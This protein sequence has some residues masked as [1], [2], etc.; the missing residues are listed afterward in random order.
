MTTYTMISFWAGNENNDH[1]NAQFQVFRVVDGKTEHAGRVAKCTGSYPALSDES[2][3]VG[4]SWRSFNW[5]ECPEGQLVE[6]YASVKRNVGFPDQC[7]IVLRARNDAALRKITA[8]LPGAG[9]STKNTVEVLGRFDVLTLDEA[10]AFGYQ[11][12]SIYEAQYDVEAREGFV[13]IDI[14]EAQR[15]PLSLAIEVYEDAV[16]GEREYIAVPKRIRKI[17]TRRKPGAR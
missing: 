14:L 8:K 3:E 1:S 15:T 12:K 4:G 6:V 10:A 17:R 13:S 7:R 2:P 11:P 5:S 9:N 16:T